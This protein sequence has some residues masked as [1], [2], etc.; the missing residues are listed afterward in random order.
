MN[1]L[2]AVVVRSLG[3]L[4]MGLSGQLNMTDTMENLV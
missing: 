2:L 1:D 4:Q 3:D